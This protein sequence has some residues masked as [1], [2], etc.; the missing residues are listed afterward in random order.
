MYL[1]IYWEDPVVAAVGLWDEKWK[2]L[3]L[4]PPS[5]RNEGVQF[6]P[7]DRSLGLAI[8]KE[9]EPGADFKR[10]LD[11]LEDAIESDA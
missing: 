6:D 9:F 4:K 11:A 5:A 1:G 7:S 2:K 10:L 3:P 8:G